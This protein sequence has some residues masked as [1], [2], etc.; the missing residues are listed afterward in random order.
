MIE[1]TNDQFFSKYISPN[2]TTRL[3]DPNFLRILRI[4][5]YWFQEK[6]DYVK[7]DDHL[8]EADL[9]Y[10]RQFT[11]LI[12]KAISYDYDTNLSKTQLKELNEKVIN[13]FNNF[14]TVLDMKFRDNDKFLRKHPSYD[15]VIPNATFLH[16][17]RVSFYWLKWS[18]KPQ[19]HTTWKYQILQAI[20]NDEN[21][22]N[23]FEK[24]VITEINNLV[25]SKFIA[26]G[27]YEKSVRK[28]LPNPAKLPSPSSTNLL[29]A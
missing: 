9:K 26:K 8:V 6:N 10:L 5:F 24:S 28:K 19:M 25:I 20:H 13:R 12:L 17:L 18:E 29:T 3:N 23:K 7:R 11:L 4:S 16:I 14:N 21:I 15:I 22:S 27:Q 1:L 2:D